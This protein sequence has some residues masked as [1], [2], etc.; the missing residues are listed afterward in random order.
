MVIEGAAATAVAACLGP[1]REEIAGKRGVV[2][3]SG[4]NIDVNLIDRIINL[5]L[6]EQGRLFRFATV[7]PD[8][9]GALS[10]LTSVLA[11]VGANIKTIRHD[12][13]LVGM[14]ILETS[15]TVELET[16]GPDHISE[17]ITR[18]RDAGYRLAIAS[19]A[20]FAD[21]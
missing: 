13:G 18:L 4:G 9:P 12:R 8:R 17:I 6:A 10:A 21:S 2:V 15:V 20:S 7:L 16:R 3:L 1:L 19:P 14:G 11:S 5:G